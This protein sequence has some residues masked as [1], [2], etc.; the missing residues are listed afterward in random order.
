[1]SKK[2]TQN[3]TILNFL[4]TG[5]RLTRRMAEAWGIQRLSARI[6]DLREDGFTIFTNKRLSTKNGRPVYH[7]RMTEERND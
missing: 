5:R 2:K 6:Y 7:Y 4:S 3:D 1:M